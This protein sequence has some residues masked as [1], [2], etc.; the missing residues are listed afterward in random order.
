MN[1]EKEPAK[2]AKIP[3]SSS[4]SKWP[5]R[6][7]LR[8]AFLDTCV[9]NWPMRD[10]DR[11]LVDVSVWRTCFPRAVCS[12]SGCN[13]VLILLNQC[14]LLERPL[15]WQQHLLGVHLQNGSTTIPDPWRHSPP[16]SSSCYFLA[17]TDIQAHGLPCYWMTFLPDSYQNLFSIVRLSGKQM[18]VSEIAFFSVECRWRQTANEMW[19]RRDQKTSVQG[20][21]RNGRQ[22]IEGAG[23]LLQ[24]IAPIP[25]VK[26]CVTSKTVF[27]ILFQNW[28][29]SCNFCGEKNKSSD[30]TK[31][32]PIDD[33]FVEH[34]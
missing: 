22:R 30:L 1:E 16:S 19:N 21:Y 11:H 31:A 32:S 9:L 34:C 12:S 5:P 15:R 27:H 4:R 8:T 33:S 2:G 14:D 18:A 23:P 17:K 29:A 28:K 26:V 13:Q 6:R 3:E 10:R 7:S 25:G 24:A 20:S